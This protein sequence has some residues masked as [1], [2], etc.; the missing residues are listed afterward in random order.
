MDIF[1]NSDLTVNPI[2]IVLKLQEMGPL[3][4][5]R[6][7]ILGK[8]WVTTD[9]K[10]AAHILKNSDIFRVRKPN[11]QAVGLQWWMPNSIRLLASNMLSMDEPEH[12]RLRSIVEQAFRRDAI[13]ALE[14]RIIEIA[15]EMAED[16]FKT[17]NEA[18]IVSTI[19]RRLPLA[20]ICELLGLPKSDRDLFLKWAEGF[21][22]V[23]GIWDF[24]KLIPNLNAMTKYLKRQIDDARTHGGNGLIAELVRIEHDEGSLSDDETVAMVFLLLVAGHETTTHLISGGMLAL[25]QN[26]EQRKWLCEDWSRGDLAIEELLRFVTPV[27]LSKPRYAYEDTSFGDVTILKGELVMTLLTAANY[28]PKLIDAPE[29]LKLDRKPNR[30]MAFGSGIHFCLG[31]QLARIEGRAAIRALL[32]RYPKLRLSHPDS[33]IKRRK[34]LG[35]NALAELMVS[36]K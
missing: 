15:E 33:A 19:A 31:H 12:K 36:P 2:S 16:L 27:Q 25:L 7:P 29:L 34:R 20:V 22:R 24:I 3:V 11:G 5:Q 10:V 17:Q 8:V 18:D 6:I 26:P 9:Q 23:N 28:D 13:M 21:M 1:K 4:R 30:H 35:L 14:P 32:T